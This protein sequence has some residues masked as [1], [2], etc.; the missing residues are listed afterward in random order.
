MSQSIPPLPKGLLFDMDG[1]L[2][3]TTQSS[4][5]RWQRVCQQF[6]PTLDLSSERLFQAFRESRS[7]Y[8]KALEHD[9][10]KRRRHHLDPF[11]RRRETVARA[12][13][14]LHTEDEALATEMVRAYE[15]LGA[16]DRHLTPAALETLQKLRDHGI[17]LA[18]ITNGNATYQR[19][20][21][22]QHH[23]E[24]FFN[25]ILI[26]G[27]FGVGKPDPRIFHAAL[28]QLQIPAQETWMVG[29]R[30]ALDIAGSQRLGIF[31]IWF[32]AAKRGLPEKS[33]I[34]PDR[35]ISTLPELFL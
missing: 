11:A 20:K 28:D 2:L 32:D 14:S 21:I 34:C 9:P 33:A 35:I 30:L 5:Q 22:W 27:E 8:K 18:L 4:E 6:A 16:E 23:L 26:E 3:I 13:A 10:E 25:V 1:V 29:D 24:P 12:L 19:Q 15:T 31:A 7:T 17:P